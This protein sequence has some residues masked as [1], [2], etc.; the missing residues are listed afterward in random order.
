VKLVPELKHF[1]ITEMP[2][3]EHANSCLVVIL[4]DHS[5]NEANI[6]ELTSAMALLMVVVV[7]VVVD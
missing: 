1:Q 3:T 7:I 4:T 2:G 5:T 6:D